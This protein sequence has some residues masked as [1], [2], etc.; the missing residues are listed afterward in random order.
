VVSRH[1]VC[2]S[3]QKK[4]LFTGAENHGAR[5]GGPLARETPDLGMACAI[6]LY[7]RTKRAAIFISDKKEV[8]HELQCLL[9]VIGVVVTGLGALS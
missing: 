8:M 1:N 5:G 4:M 9:Y 3:L 2:R 6:M 7:F